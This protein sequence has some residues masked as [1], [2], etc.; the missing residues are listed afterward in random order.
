MWHAQT[1]HSGSRHPKT[2]H[3]G[4]FFTLK[5]RE[6]FAPIFHRRSENILHIRWPHRRPRRR[7]HRRVATARWWAAT[8][9]PLTS[10]SSSRTTFSSSSFQILASP[11]SPRRL[12]YLSRP[13][14]PPELMPT[15]VAAGASH[16]DRRRRCRIYWGP[17]SGSFLCPHQFIC[18]SCIPTEIE[19]K[20]GLHFR[21]RFLW[22]PQTKIG[23]K[24]QI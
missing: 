21:P 9:T 12:G 4:K 3:K 14:P 10:S 20:C 16:F 18:N 13:P 22:Q 6:H 23:T 24:E 8:A 1:L 15:A 11:S 5:K 19:S 2:W 7:P 17:A